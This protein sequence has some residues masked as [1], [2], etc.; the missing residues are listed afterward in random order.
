MTTTQIEAIQELADCTRGISLRIPAPEPERQPARLT[1][2]QERRLDREM[3]HV[4]LIYGTEL[5]R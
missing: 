4:L 1:R 3:R 2:R 5:Q